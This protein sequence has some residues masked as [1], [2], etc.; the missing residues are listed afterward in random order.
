MISIKVEKNMLGI[1]T[2]LAITSA[3][4]RSQLIVVLLVVSMSQDAPAIP[5]AGLQEPSITLTVTLKL[6]RAPLQTPSQVIV[7]RTVA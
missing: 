7:M 5:F 6:V 4:F 1:V 3:L 2:S